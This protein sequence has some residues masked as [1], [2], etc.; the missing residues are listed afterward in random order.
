MEG[1]DSQTRCKSSKRNP[2]IKTACTP[3]SILGCVDPRG[4]PPPTRKKDQD[5]DPD[6]T[7]IQTRGKPR[8][9]ARPVPK[10]DHERDLEEDTDKDC[11]E[12]TDYLRARG[13][14]ADTYIY[15]YIYIYLY[16]YMCV[17]C[18]CDVLD[19]VCPIYCIL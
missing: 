6:H 3:I 4:E 1:I 10:A 15:I 16:T 9:R 7:Q 5:P 11:N 19:I 18:T 12:I 14:V 2:K 8:P 17:S 13:P